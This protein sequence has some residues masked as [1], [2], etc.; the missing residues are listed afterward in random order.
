MSTIDQS[1][2][3]AYDIRGIVGEALTE[4]VVE[5]IGLAVGSE[6]Q[7]RGVDTI[8]VGRDGR[9]SGPLLQQALMSGLKK[10]R[11]GGD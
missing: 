11:Y 2:F 1:I 4:E 7:A 8:V 9:L 6:S 10:L 5:Q 3:R